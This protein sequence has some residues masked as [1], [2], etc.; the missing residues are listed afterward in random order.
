[1]ADTIAEAIT[2]LPRTPDLF[3]TMDD[4]DFRDFVGDHLG[5]DE[6]AALWNLLLNPDL[7]DR[8]KEALT[9]IGANLGVQG[10]NRRAEIHT[11][12]LDCLARGDEGLE[13]YAAAKAEY[14]DWRA[15][16]GGYRRLVD[17]RLRQ[18]RSAEKTLRRRQ[19][20][21]HQARNV[22]RN[23]EVACRL[24]IGVLQHRRTM[25]QAGI[26]PDDHDVA[27][28]RLLDELT[29]AAGGRDVTLA[30]AVEYGFWT[31]REGE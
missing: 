14:D 6:P 16:S 10:A 4:E 15:R 18:V 25:L 26:T 31:V 24:T 9:D 7:F 17:R 19:H 1:M 2:T 29:I 28:W 20:D 21:A 30:E 5:P 27:L 22:D 3:D 13:D 11:Y 23:R 8:T 12:R